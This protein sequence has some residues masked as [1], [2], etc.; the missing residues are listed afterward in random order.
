MARL[1]GKKIL[2]TGAD[3]FIGSHLVEALVREGASVRALVFYN[4]L[5][6]WGWLENAPADVRDQFQ[7]VAG[8]IRDL[9][10]VLSAVR[11]CEIVLH[12]AALISIPYS[13]LSAAAFIDTN[14]SGTLNI[15]QASR[16]STVSRLV[17]TSSTSVSSSSLFSPFT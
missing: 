16:D 10:F 1:S 9:H 4:S 2:V 13:Y 8:D 6:S 11:E 17:C 14:V 5:N 12:L 7:V 3:G 15:L